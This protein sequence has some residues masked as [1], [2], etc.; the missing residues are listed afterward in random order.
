MVSFKIFFHSEDLG[1]KILFQSMDYN[2]TKTE[3]MPMD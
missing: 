1:C 2:I 3:K